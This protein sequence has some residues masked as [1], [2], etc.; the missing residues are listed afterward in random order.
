MHRGGAVSGIAHPQFKHGRHSKYLPV[1]L[2]ERYQEALADPELLTMRHE[3]ALVDARLAELLERINHADSEQLWARARTALANYLAAQQ[4]RDETGSQQALQALEQAL[5]GGAE[6]YAAWNAIHEVIEQR[7]RLTESERKRLVEMQQML[8]TEQAMV[9]LAAV[10]DTVRR[11]VTDRTALAAI[12]AD[13]GRLVAHRA[14][15][16]PR[17]G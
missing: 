6:D 3:L 4:S 14:L 5:N 17:A 11:H 13:L 9:L 10:V 12:S 15:D 16:A 2:A 7:R 1:R 8:S